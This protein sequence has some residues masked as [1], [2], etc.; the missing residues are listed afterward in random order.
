M[1][2]LYL[3]IKTSILIKLL[4]ANGVPRVILGTVTW[5][6]RPGDFPRRWDKAANTLLFLFILGSLGT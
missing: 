4:M 6:V 5:K 2:A 3:S 1:V